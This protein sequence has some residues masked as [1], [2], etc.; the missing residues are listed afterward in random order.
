MSYS[1]CDMCD[2]RDRIRELQRELDEAI[3]DINFN[4][5]FSAQV[6]NRLAV[7]EERFATPE[8]DK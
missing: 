7:L 3:T 4:R 2:L 8:G 5:G 6:E 1:E